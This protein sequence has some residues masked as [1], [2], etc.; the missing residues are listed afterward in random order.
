MPQPF[1]GDLAIDK[2]HF[3]RMINDG[4]KQSVALHRDDTS[5]KPSN[6]LVFNLCPDPR[7]P[8]AC[9]YKLDTVREDSDG[10]RR[11]LMVRLQDERTLAALKQLDDLAVSTAL[12]NCKEWFKKPTMSEAEV[13]LRYKPL[14]LED[15]GEHYLKFKVKCKGYVTELHLLREDNTVEENG[16]TLEHISEYGAFVAPILCCFSVWFMG[17]GTSFGISAQAE[18]MVVRPG[19]PR[20]ALSDFCCEE[21]LD[22]VVPQKKRPREG[23]DLLPEYEAYTEED[24]IVLDEE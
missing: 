10:S 14:V 2:V 6:K 13:R 11:G 4:S 24:R 19:A 20:P 9:R 16:G 23:E 3:G 15:G 8:F 18:K 22:V 17:G 7:K 1:I 21:P 5:F 12:S